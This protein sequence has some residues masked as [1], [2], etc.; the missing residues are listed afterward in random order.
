M[1]IAY[2]T[3]LQQYQRTQE[4]QENPKMTHIALASSLA[5]AAG[6]IGA[7]FPPVGIGLGLLV[8]GGGFIVRDR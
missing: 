5:L 3:K 6:T 1:L 8:L 7:F 2:L 4:L